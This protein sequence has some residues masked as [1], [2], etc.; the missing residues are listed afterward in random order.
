LDVTPFEV[1]ESYLDEEYTNNRAKRLMIKS[2]ASV[3]PSVRQVAAGWS[4]GLR[5]AWPSTLA[6]RAT[7]A[8]SQPGR[9]TVATRNEAITAAHTIDVATRG[10]RAASAARKRSFTKS[11]KSNGPRSRHLD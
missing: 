7:C 3:G 4:G 10:E 1:Y 11:R 2:S 9:V 5:S 8:V 6:R